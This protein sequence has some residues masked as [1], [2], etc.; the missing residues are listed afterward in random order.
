MAERIEDYALI[1]DCHT[2]ALVSRNGSIDWL[3]LP[4]FDSGACFSALLGAERNGRWLLAPQDH[5]K[6]KRCYQGNTLVLETE[7]ETGTGVAAVIDFMPARDTVPNLVR[8]VEGRSGVVNMHSELIIRFDY[9]SIMPWVERQE[10][11]IRAIAGPD[12]LC[13][14]TPVELRGKDFTTVCDFEVKAGERIPFV[15]SWHPSY[16]SQPGPVDPEAALRDTLNWWNEWSRR[17]CYSGDWN[18]EVLR[19]LLTLKALIYAPTGGI[20]AAPTTSLPEF[21]GGVRNWDYRYCWLRDATFTLYSLL[22][23]D[24]TEEAKAWTEWLLRAVAG[25]P[26]KTQIMYGLAGER[27]LT[28]LEISWLTGYENSAPVRI[29]NAASQQFQLDVY[30]ELLDSMFQA[31]K[32]GLQTLDAA[33][34]LETAFVSF[35]Q[36]AWKEPD[37]GIWEIRGER[38]HFTHSKVM[39]WV[40]V[41]RAVRLIEEHGLKGPLEE[42]RKLRQAIH[43]DVCQKGFDS[44]LD[45]F[46]QAY[47]SK[48]LDASLLMIPLV[49]FLPASDPRVMGTVAAIERDLIH[50]GFVH[51]YNTASTVDGLPAG[52]G[53]FLPCTLWLADNYVL[54]GRK[55]EAAEILKRVLSVS[56]DVGLLAEEYDP[57][58]KRLLGNFPQAF[59]HV[60][61]I[62]TALNLSEAGGPAEQ[63]RKSK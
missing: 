49:G 29:G 50:S 59:S 17:S 26:N 38:Q 48:Q 37:E 39:A 52:E 44:S 10:G 8:I 14:R 25:D 55:E 33:W 5:A 58:L 62:N 21:V 28:E 35:L 11:G 2:A 27:R 1:G 57:K 20:V 18:G 16:E 53:V 22:N 46:V 45:S 51:R 15:M 60:G 63:R 41:D 12:S 56:N 43:E 31:R 42:W 13:I 7:F 24:Y 3:C 30:G 40:A 4:R 9:G 61:V 32:A 34:R 19:S 47:G 54:Q 6:V 23:C 36:K